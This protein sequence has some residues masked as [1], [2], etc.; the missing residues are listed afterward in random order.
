[1]RGTVLGSGDPAVKKTKSSTDRGY[2]LIRWRQIIR[3]ISK[4]HG[5]ISV[6]EKIKQGR[7]MGSVGE[8]WLL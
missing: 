7:G 2:I 4:M 1:M 5:I 3:K 8:G 6:R